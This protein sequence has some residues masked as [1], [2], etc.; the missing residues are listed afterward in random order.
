MVLFFDS[1][2]LI[3]NCLVDVDTAFQTLL[4]VTATYIKLRYKIAYKIIFSQ[5]IIKQCP[6]LVRRQN[7]M[8]C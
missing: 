8:G 1:L 3:F 4:L 6:Y 2:F 7:N 5:C